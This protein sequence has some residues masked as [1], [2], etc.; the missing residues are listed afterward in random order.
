MKFPHTKF[1]LSLVFTNLL[2]L[3]L[4]SSSNHTNIFL[5]CLNKQFK[6]S[7]SSTNVIITPTQNA[8]YYASLLQPQNLRPESTFPLKPLLILTPYQPTQIQASIFCAKKLD[9]EIRTRSGG[10]DYEGLSYTS[11]NP[12]FIIVDMRNLGSIKIDTG[13][14]TA[15]VETG[16]T[17][18]QLYHALAKKSKTLTFPMG[19]C[20]T[21]GVGGHFS[22]GGYGML[23]RKYGLASDHIIDAKLID[24]DGNIL[25]GGSMGEDLLWALRGGGSA[26][27]GI[28]LAF[29]VSLVVVPEIVTGFIV[30][31]T[32]NVAQLVYTWQQVADKVDEDL[33]L[34]V[35]LNSVGSTPTVTG[36]KNRTI[37]A[38]FNALYLGRA[39]DLLLLMEREFPELR[40]VEKECTEMSWIESVLYFASLRNRTVDVLL[41]PTP[42]KP[43]APSFYKGKSDFVTTIISVKG[44]SR[45]WRFLDEEA[46]H[47]GTLEFSPFGGKVSNFSESATPFPNRA[48]NIFMIR[49]GVVWYGEGDEELKK[50]M[51]WIR[52]VYSY[53]ARYASKSPRRAYF[54]YKDLD[55][56]MN[57]K[58]NTS[59]SQASV[60]GHKYFKGNFDRLVLAKTKAD[61]SNFFRN[62]QSIPLVTL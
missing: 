41:S 7:N 17:L 38:T 9:T 14:K 45:I 6:R 26:S 13:A 11:R 27:F 59:Y 50:H 32:K 29:K 3:G 40:L 10:H 62:E 31:R 43:F 61:P 42:Q 16:A 49:Y 58:E 24:A 18:G 12:N 37:V 53:M 4:S 35:S 28:I 1:L 36:G 47:R 30:A 54:N 52:S 44:L 46:E 60:W 22:G 51:S 21:V 20:P 55:I 25:D 23:S 5:K 8:S 56:G 33:L 34:R 15:W 48:G 2:V 19:V 39:N 57:D